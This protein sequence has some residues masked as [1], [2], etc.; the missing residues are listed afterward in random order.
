MKPKIGIKVYCIYGTGIMVDYVGHVGKNSFII[1]SY[2]VCTEPDSWEWDYDL[3]GEKWF[4]SL[5]K[6]K[7]K[8]IDMYK[9]KYEN[10]LK[11]E[12]VEDSWYALKFC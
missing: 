3:Y 10:E 2:G 8:L 11:I 12:K 5:F 1:D 7:K 6:A 4:T 9:D